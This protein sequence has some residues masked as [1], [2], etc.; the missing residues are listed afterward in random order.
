MGDT[1]LCLTNGDGEN[2]QTAQDCGVQTASDDTGPA[3]L[4]E[5]ARLIAEAHEDCER[6]DQQQ[7]EFANRS[8]DAALKAG[9]HL[10]EAKKL[11]PFG[12]WA[13]WVEETCSFCQRTAENYMKLAKSK[14]IADFEKCSSLREAYI[15]G[16]IIKR[17]KPVN[18]EHCLSTDAG[19]TIEEKE[20]LI[21]KSNFKRPKKWLAGCGNCISDTKM[22]RK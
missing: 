22:M 19:D 10:N 7:R 15:L 14:H 9:D 12:E 5:L 4:G 8:I 17:P 16:G 3:R 11:V 2:S 18:G 21:I 13:A 20:T 6:F 1:M